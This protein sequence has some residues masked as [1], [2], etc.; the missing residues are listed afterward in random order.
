MMFVCFCSK[1]CCIGKSLAR[2]EMNHF[3][4]NFSRWAN[5]G[6][7]AVFLQCQAS[8]QE[9]RS[10]SLSVFYSH[11]LGMFPVPPC[12]VC[13]EIGGGLTSSSHSQR[14]FWMEAQG[15]WRST[16]TPFHE[17]C[18]A[19]TYSASF[20]RQ[21]TESTFSPPN[22]QKSKNVIVHHLHPAKWIAFPQCRPIL[23][24]VF[25]PFQNRASSG[26]NI[27]L[28]QTPTVERLI[29]HHHGWKAA[30]PLVPYAQASLGVD[31]T[32][33]VM[34][35]AEFSLKATA[36]SNGGTMSSVKADLI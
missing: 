24:V 27:I 2:T 30:D 15:Q 32:M 4:P 5:R 33:L 16:W 28:G 19:H 1:V 6:E 12:V 35:G 29:Y 7:M 8:W 20:N 14:P 31:W 23:W 22:H 13:T 21:Q 36:E 25:T 26:H 3:L 18:G 11:R 10:Q 34:G 9:S 17:A